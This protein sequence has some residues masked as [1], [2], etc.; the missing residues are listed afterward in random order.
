MWPTDLVSVLS[1][2]EYINTAIKFDNMNCVYPTRQV[3]HHNNNIY[4]SN[5][6]LYY[7]RNSQCKGIFGVGRC[8]P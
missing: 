2:W 5:I 6:S 3:S 8:L 7:S 1:S 4:V